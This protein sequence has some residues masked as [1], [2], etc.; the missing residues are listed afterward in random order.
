MHVVYGGAFNPPTI[1]HLEV[2]YFLEDRLN[3]S[4]FTYLPVSSAYTKSSLVSNY[5]RL[6]MLELMTQSID[7]IAISDLE[8]RD[9]LFEGTYQSLVRL[10]DD[11]KEPYAFVIGADNIGD[12]AS[13]KMASSLLGEFKLIVLGRHGIDVQTLIDSDDFLSKYR[14]NFIVFEDFNCD[15]SSTTFRDTLDKSM[16]HEAVYQ[17]IIDQDLYKR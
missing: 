9:E 17:Y 2:F 1:A 7:K 10:S 5:H 13:W 16:V 3:V 8:M 12:L 4:S 15:V 6:K 14:D 11:S